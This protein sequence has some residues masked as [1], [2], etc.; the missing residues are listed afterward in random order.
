MLAAKGIKTKNRIHL[1][2]K[3]DEE[4]SKPA[5]PSP[6]D[7]LKVHGKKP[8]NV[9]EYKYGDYD[10]VEKR[11]ELLGKG[12]IALLGSDGDK[13]IVEDY[14]HRD[15]ISKE[16][17]EQIKKMTMESETPTIHDEPLKESIMKVEPKIDLLHDVLGFGR[18]ADVTVTSDGFFM[19]RKHGDIGYNEFLGKPSDVAQQRARKTYEQLDPVTR[20][21]VD[22]SLKSKGLDR[23]DIFGYEEDES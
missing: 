12:H 6:F 20:S 14:G 9:H 7:I 17:D 10:A 19:G 3:P 13:F 1:Q 4:K 2:K 23:S 18:F 16:E 8:K 15:D 5:A 11:S 21:K 22:A